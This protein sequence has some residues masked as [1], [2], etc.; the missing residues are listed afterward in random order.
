[1]VDVLEDPAIAPSLS[2][3]TRVTGAVYAVTT[4][5]TVAHLAATP[6]V[7]VPQLVQ[8]LAPQAV[9][10]ALDIVGD[11]APE[12]VAGIGSAIPLVGTA[13][14]V[15][16]GAFGAIQSA[17]AAAA[18]AAE[19]RRQAEI[20]ECI[21][22]QKGRAVVNTGPDG[23]PVPSDFFSTSVPVGWKGPGKPR[24][25]HSPEMPGIGLLLRLL[26][27]HE[28]PLLGYVQRANAWHKWGLEDVWFQA[29]LNSQLCERPGHLPGEAGCW[30]GDPRVDEFAPVI[31]TGYARQFETLRAAIE[32][33]SPAY[34]EPR[35][36]KLREGGRELWPMYMDLL[37]DAILRSRRIF[38]TRD[39]P[40][41]PEWHVL[42]ELSKTP[43]TPY[44][45]GFGDFLYTL[46]QTTASIG[47]YAGRAPVRDW[48]TSSGEAFRLLDRQ[49]GW[50]AVDWAT[51]SHRVI[52]MAYDWRLTVDPIYESDRTEL[53]DAIA[54]VAQGASVAMRDRF[55]AAG[56]STPDERVEAMADVVAEQTGGAIDEKEARERISWGKAAGLTAA[57][58]AAV[59]LAVYTMR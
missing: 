40:V 1:M 30:W 8:S 13:I 10:M 22:K 39:V 59:G 31:R 45:G 42:G 23:E 44:V 17:E 54:Q 58:A 51:E 49:G 16:V 6:E 33:E 26:T 47:A 19:Q 50:C 15:M 52:E 32:R 21:G 35:G 25:E 41:L 12:I 48:A 57:A 38:E 3:P 55:A 7:A 37:S 36:L 18:A 53:E 2:Y 20:A 28:Y 46:Q 11:V 43:S 24:W 5:E 56:G 29:S 14:D 4:F 9:N 27:E 34:R